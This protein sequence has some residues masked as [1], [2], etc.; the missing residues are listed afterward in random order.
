VRRRLLVMVGRLRMVFGCLAMMVRGF[1]GH[2]HS[3]TQEPSL[4]SRTVGTVLNGW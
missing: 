1:F 3:F 2:V 4:G